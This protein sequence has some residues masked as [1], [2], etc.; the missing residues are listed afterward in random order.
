MASGGIERS[1]QEAAAA[2]RQARAMLDA[3]FR[4]A[5]AEPA[6]GAIRACSRAG[7]AIRTRS[8]VDQEEDATEQRAKKKTPKSN[9]VNRHRDKLLKFNDMQQPALAFA[10]AGSRSLPMPS[11]RLDQ[12]Q[13]KEESMPLPV[14]SSRLGQNHVKQEI[15]GSADRAAKGDYREL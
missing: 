8:R 7:H 14:P 11:S 1:F 9:E 3:A 2:R 12:S 15:G 10:A 13:V 5:E 6:G 4:A